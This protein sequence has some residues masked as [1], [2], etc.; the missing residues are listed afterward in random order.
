[1]NMINKPNS[2]W[3]NKTLFGTTLASLLLLSCSEKVIIY[4]NGN[5]ERQQQ[6]QS[7][8]KYLSFRVESGN[9]SDQNFFGIIIHD[10][11][12]KEVIEFGH[13]KIYGGDYSTFR[14]LD[15]SRKYRIEVYDPGYDVCYDAVWDINW[16]K[17]PTW[18]NT[19]RSP[20]EDGPY[21]G[22]G[23]HFS[24]VQGCWGN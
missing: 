4:E 13:S 10:Q 1:M 16:A 17:N 24:E 11:E 8:F 12:T 15:S 5:E 19:E 3:R 14:K 18:W 6:I 9:S 23:T 2:R 7:P 20:K 21:I 22:L